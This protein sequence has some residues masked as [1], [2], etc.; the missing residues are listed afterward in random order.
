MKTL[1]A[2]LFVAVVI[3]AGSPVFTFARM[4][5]TVPV[6]SLCGSCSNG[7]VVLA[8]DYNL[9]RVFLNRGHAHIYLSGDGD[10]DLDM[11]VY[12]SNGNEVG[13]RVGNVDD[14]SM[15][16]NIYR[17]G[18]FTIKVVNIGSVYNNYRLWVE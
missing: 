12:D 3:L 7:H 10:T 2:K 18:W 1:V 13:R 15:G 9:H 14:E 4:I 8:R 5:P 6:A 11:Y 17:S 16:V